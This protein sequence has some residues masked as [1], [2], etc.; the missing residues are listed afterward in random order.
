M[1]FADVIFP[2]FTLPFFWFWVP[3]ALPLALASEAAVFWFNYRQIGSWRLLAGV[4][5]ANAFSWIVGILIGMVTVPLLP[6]GIGMSSDQKT[7]EAEYL[8]PYVLVL[9]F[10]AFVLSTLLEYPVWKLLGRKQPFKSLFRTTLIA[11]A[12]SYLILVGILIIFQKAFGI[13]IG[14]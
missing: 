13:E 12:A 11:N 2:I 4:L 8:V 5:G 6:P 1:F 7:F 3:W 9:F 10:I 14:F